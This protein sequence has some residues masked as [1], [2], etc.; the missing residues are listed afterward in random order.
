MNNSN[1]IMNIEKKYNEKKINKL[2]DHEINSL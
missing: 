2:N 1:S